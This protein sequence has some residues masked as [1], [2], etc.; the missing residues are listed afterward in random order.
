LS[1]KSGD[2]CAPDGCAE[3]AGSWSQ[4]KNGVVA[5]LQFEK[6]RNVI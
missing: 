4:K 3:K 5:A 6:T 1:R 2:A